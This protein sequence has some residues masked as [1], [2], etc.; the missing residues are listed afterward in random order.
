[1]IAVIFVMGGDCPA[2]LP[3]ASPARRRFGAPSRA[4]FDS[5]KGRA[6]V[7]LWIPACAGMTAGGI[8][9]I[10]EQM[11]RSYGIGKRTV[12]V[13][14]SPT[15][16]CTSTVPLWISTMFLVIESPSPKPVLSPDD[17]GDL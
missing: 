1:M 11:M 7:P 4:P 6:G 14:P 2:R 15:T 3:R 9:G 13:E 8:K 5:R 12:N 10:G 17:R 16:L